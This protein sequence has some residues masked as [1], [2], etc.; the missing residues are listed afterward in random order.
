MFRATTIVAVKKGNCVAIA[1]D[2]QV[3]F[4][5][6][7]IIK[8]TANKIRKIYNDKVLI[9]FAGSVADAFSL[10]E[11]F[12]DKLVEFNGNL[13]KAAV[14]LANFWRSDKALR[15]LE[16]LMIAADKETLLII[17]GGGEVIEPDD[18][19]AAVGSGGM[20][21][22]AAARALMHNTDLT[23]KEIAYKSLVIASEI[24]VYTNSNIN[25]LEL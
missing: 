7:T 1:G 2:G 9:G 16:A 21:A 24:C 5:E 20:Y 8:S 17:S 15:K 6:S 19:I 10:A 12:E 22:L 23:P 13:R 14:E 25:V 11:K 3:T 18:G 4:G